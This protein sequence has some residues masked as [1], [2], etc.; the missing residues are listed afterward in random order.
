M[1]HTW[2]EFLVIKLV[3]FGS[4]D[5][6]S[7]SVSCGC[8]GPGALRLNISWRCLRTRIRQKGLTRLGIR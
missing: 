6:T 8:N 2:V 4:F 3:A 1:V 5:E 7:C